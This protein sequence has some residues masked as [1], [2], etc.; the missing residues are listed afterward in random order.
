MGF[1]ENRNR[2]TIGPR[3]EPLRRNSTARST[4]LSSANRSKVK[5]EAVEY[6]GTR[7]PRKQNSHL[8][9]RPF[10]ISEKKKDCRA[11]RVKSREMMRRLIA[12]FL[13]VFEVTRNIT[14]YTDS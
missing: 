2:G 4:R 5:D 1:D 7:Y 13:L 10:S 3:K 8:R 9:S 6:K 14:K 11:K 12:R